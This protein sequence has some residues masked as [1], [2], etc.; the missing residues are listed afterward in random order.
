M[1][2]ILAYINS[3][4]NRIA[5]NEDEKLISIVEELKLIDNATEKVD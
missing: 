4:A 1:E 3:L 2:G 5:V